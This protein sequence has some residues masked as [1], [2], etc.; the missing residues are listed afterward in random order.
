[1][2]ALTRTA[3][4][5]VEAIDGETFVGQKVPAIMEI[6]LL[7]AHAQPKGMTRKAIGIAAKC[8][9]PSVTNSLKG[10]ISDRQAH[11]SSNGEYFITSAGEQVLA[12]WLNG[13]HH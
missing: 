10:L 12:N 11:F 8:S 1:M 5:F 6:L 3:I 9:Q 2:A 4:P 7:L 13:R